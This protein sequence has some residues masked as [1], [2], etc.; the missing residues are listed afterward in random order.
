[1]QIRSVP[2]QGTTVELQLPAHP[3]SGANA[4]G[5]ALD[6]QEL[7]SMRQLEV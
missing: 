6:A 2:G 1:V 4:G 7:A 5:L 3:V